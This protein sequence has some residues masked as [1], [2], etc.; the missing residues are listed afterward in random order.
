MRRR[1][2]PCPRGASATVAPA[3][4][5]S[6]TVAPANAAIASD[7]GVLRLCPVLP[8]DP[9]VLNIWCSVRQPHFEM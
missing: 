7:V 5:A 1:R 6:P 3:S 8:S 4:A 2:I 9:S